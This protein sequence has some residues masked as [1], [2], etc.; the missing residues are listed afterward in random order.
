MLKY[1]LLTGS[2]VLL[3][4][5]LRAQQ[6]APSPKVPSEPLNV[7]EQ[8]QTLWKQT[9]LNK[10]I[11]DSVNARSGKWLQAP[12]TVLRAV[13]QQSKAL[14]SAYLSPAATNQFMQYMANTGGKGKVQQLQQALRVVKDTGKINHYFDNKLRGFY[15]LRQQLP[16]PKKGQ[17]LLKV[18]LKQVQAGVV[19]DNAPAAI[20]R[21]YSNIQ[22][23]GSV[24]LAGIPFAVNGTNLN[25]AAPAW[26]NS[27]MAQL[28]KAGFDKQAFLEQL[29]ARVSKD[30]DLRKYFL[31]DIDVK[32]AVKQYA[33]ARVKEIHGK[34][35]SLYKGGT[36]L[37]PSEELLQL[38]SVQLKNLVMNSGKGLQQWGD[39]TLSE[40]QSRNKYLQELLQMKQSLGKE[41]DLKNTLTGSFDAKQKLTGL[42]N[43]VEGR[44]QAAKDL[45]PLNGLEKLFLKM[46]TLNIG[47][48]GV[49]ASKGNVSDLFMTGAAGTL[50]DNNRL[51]MLGVGKRKDAAG[52]RDAAFTSSLAPTD[53]SLQFLR[54]GKGDIGEKHS[55][56]GIVNANTKDANRRQF[57]MP[58]LPRNAFN[59]SFSKQ[60]SLGE[61]GTLNAEVSKSNNVF[62]GGTGKDGSALG[63]K[64]AAFSLMDD[65][66]STFSAGLGWNGDVK[67]W[68]STHRVYVNYA[69]LGYNNPAS[70]YAARGSWQYGFKVKKRFQRNRLQLGARL[71]QKNM[72]T[73][74]VYNSSWKSTQIGFDGRYKL[75]KHV[76]FDARYS[77]AVMKHKGGK[78]DGGDFVNR[79]LSMSSMINGRLFNKPSN[80]HVMLA[81]QQ[82]EQQSA[83]IPLNS[84]MTNINL[85]QTLTF[86][87]NTL[88]MNVFYNRDIKDNALYGN[89]L[90]AEASW[91]YQL[92]ERVSCSSGLTYLSNTG[93]VKQAGVKQHVQT[94]LLPK[95][96][97]NAY[98]D[99][100]TSFLNSAQNYL[101][102]NFR[103]ELS[104]L[105]TL[106]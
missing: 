5:A 85:T 22:I 9:P 87:T 38:D 66:W 71:D 74:T 34:L 55:H 3:C 42:M 102:G 57:N 53:Y 82:M 59:L 60:M 67:E 91:N 103:G 97:M 46:K 95:L 11:A 106:D 62:A 29:S 39:S 8:A 14:M 81:F 15:A 94:M 18:N 88:V 90:T 13:G 104:F 47:D 16:L 17:D 58:A 54:M 49:D 83:T 69:G 36:A 43:S 37:I 84:L 1:I 2:G 26:D 99:C 19:T 45:L 10:A 76:S 41:L 56:I 21:T 93:I 35:D 61:Y 32:A 98:V 105:Y 30:Y 80:S 86:K 48:I 23:N 92:W 100:R 12:D 52:M 6:A 89:L 28:V 79:L 24:A 31:D 73:S 63:S 75:D 65:F 77:Q 25:T 40:Q 70:P 78:G 20:A 4:V 27:R 72:S 96:S 101:F 44:K 33:D 7:K 68:Q 64:A 50:L 51:L